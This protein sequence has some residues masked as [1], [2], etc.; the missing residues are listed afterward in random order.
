MTVLPKTKKALV[1]ERSVQ[2]GT[3]RYPPAY[4]SL[5]SF[6]C[7]TSDR[8]PPSPT[9]RKTRRNLSDV[10]ST[11]APPPKKGS[12]FY[13][14]RWVHPLLPGYR[15]RSGSPGINSD[16]ERTPGF[17]DEQLE[18]QFADR[19]RASHGWQI[20]QMQGDG[21]CLFR[22][23]GRLSTSRPLRTK[24]IPADQVYGDEE[25]HGEVRRL[26]MDYMVRVPLN[27]IRNSRFRRGIETTLR[28]L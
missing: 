10:P 21:A 11:S 13:Y 27:F 28:S 25:M 24:P 8:R 2:P 19:L 4:N 26:C 14:Y 22:A 1:K 3:S 20:K 16:D 15:S 23:V 5:S 12:F 18:L 6:S 17:R 7:T 9:N